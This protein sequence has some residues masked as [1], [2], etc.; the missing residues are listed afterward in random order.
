MKLKKLVGL[1]AVMGVA[2]PGAAFAT[3]GMNLEGYGPIAT[4]MGGA[5]FAYDNGTAAMANNPATLALN[6]SNA[7]L[8]LAVG[9][10]G[11]D[12][13]SNAAGFSAPSA[14]DA[15][16]MPAVGYVRR[17]G[18][19]TYGVGVFAQG[20]MGTE[21]GNGS[22]L[23]AGTGQEVRSEVGVGRLIFPLAMNV[24][25]RLTLG[26]SLDYV[27]AGMDL[28]MPLTNTQF[29]AMMGGNGG[30]INASAGFAGMLGGPG[31][32]AGYFNFSNGN[33][34]TGQA[35]ATG[36]GAKIGFTYKATPNLSIGGTYHSKTNLSDLETGDNAASMTVY[37]GATA[38]ASFTGK[39]RVVN[40]Q[41]PE[42]YGFGL[43]YTPNEKWLVAADYKRI[44]WSG[45]MKN[46]Q[47][48]FTTAAMG[49]NYVD[50]V[51]K[52]DWSDQD[53]FELGFS[54]KP[55]SQWVVRAGINYA[56]NPVP[57]TYVNALFPAIETT[58]YTFGAG[59]TFSPASSVDFS[60]TYAPKVT[61]T[62]NG[63]LNTG[64]TSSMSQLNW[65]LMYSHRF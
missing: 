29:G 45:V 23:S 40:F 51:M 4:G 61:V 20:G 53:V 26:G 44:N 54:Y 15:Y 34:F 11:P 38:I 8:D 7:R 58:H 31:W 30:G 50:A 28:K 41:W 5:S 21:Y 25:D 56:D 18:N 14:G 16:Y 49:G 2:V 3:N 46:F 52:Q 55:T 42:T 36:W 57:N 60:M 48:Q 22:F 59:Y 9:M 27:W 37:N 24:S 6:Q 35:K 64:V 32:T 39:M 63:P 47:M 19:L 12:V 1:L 10:L 43:A 33:K 65:Q 13:N 62:G 17:S